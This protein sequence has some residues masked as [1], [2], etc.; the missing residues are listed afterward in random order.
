MSAVFL[1][2]LLLFLPPLHAPLPIGTE[3]FPASDEGQIRMPI[4]LPVGSS[5]EETKK[6]V[7]KV[8]ESFSRMFPSYRLSNHTGGFGQGHGSLQ[9][10]VFRPHM[11]NRLLTLV[12]QAE[13][14]RSSEVIAR[15]LREKVRRFPAPSSPSIPGGIISRVINIGADEPIDIEV[16]GYELD[17]GTPLG[18]KLKRS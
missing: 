1:G 10:K 11:G 16:L 2:T 18:R 9:R 5:L 6:V 7:E 17:T 8:E 14:D 4:R 15:M 12:P 3:F 13:R